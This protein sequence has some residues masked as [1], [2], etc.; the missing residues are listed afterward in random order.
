MPNPAR[1]FQTFFAYQQSAAMKAAIDLDVFTSIADRQTTAEQIAERAG[2][3]ERGIRILCD[4]LTVM[5]FL[6]KNDSHYGL[7]PDSAVFLDRR[8]PAYMGSVANFLDAPEL[9]HAFDHL[10]DAVRKGGTVMSE[11]GTVSYDNP[12]WVQFAHSMAPMMKMPAEVI[13]QLVGADKGGKCRVLDIAAGHGLFG[14][15]IARH[16]PQAEIVALD[17]AN[18]LEVAKENARKS[19]VESRYSTLA[20]SAFE[21]D[22]GQGYDLV[23]ITNF[24]H[25]FDPPTNEGLLRKVHATLAPNGRAVTLEFVPNDDRVSPPDAATFSMVMLGSTAHGDA[26]TFAELDR[27]F[28]NAGFSR[29]EHFRQAPMPESVIISHR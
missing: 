12:I 22:F 4:Y 7:S 28:S 25:H 26:Y 17:W 13:S 2:A 23:L 14:I 6:T 18:V 1:L 24:L 10:A 11:E 3:A 27:M 5:G 29:S 21:V 9:L 15:D 20:G 8:S 16:N 19:G